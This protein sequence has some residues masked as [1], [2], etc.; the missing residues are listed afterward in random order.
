VG[1]KF[2]IRTVRFEKLTAVRAMWFAESFRESES[3][4]KLFSVQIVHSATVAPSLARQE[5]FLL[6]GRRRY[7]FGV[8]R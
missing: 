1:A 4:K 7:G 5:E 6:N 2:E 3:S 8:Q